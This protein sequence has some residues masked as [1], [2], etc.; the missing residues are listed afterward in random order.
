MN[1]CFFALITTT[2]I[3]SALMNPSGRT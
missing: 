1:D 2:R 3:E